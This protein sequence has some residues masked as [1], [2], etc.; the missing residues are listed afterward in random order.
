MGK[1]TRCNMNVT[2]DRHSAN[3]GQAANR[4]HGV[5]RGRAAN[6]VNPG[7]AGF[8]TAAV[9]VLLIVAVVAGAY[10]LKT[11]KQRAATAS[12]YFQARSATY[13]AQAG[14]DAALADLEAQPAQGTQTLNTFL[15]DTTK[16]WLFGGLSK[17]GSPNWTKLGEGG[18]TYATRLVAFDPATGLVKL[19]ARGRGPGGSESQVFGVYQLQG[20]KLVNDLLPRH[21]WYIAGD[22]RNIDETLDIDGNAYFGGNVHINGGADGTIFRGTVKVARG[23]GGVSS[24]DAGVTFAEHAYFQTPLTTQGAGLVFQ[25]GAGFEN[26]IASNTDMRMTGAGQTAYFNANISGGNAGINMLGNRVVHNGTLNMAR[27]KN[28][29]QVTQQ[30]GN[31]A[32]ANALGMT[33]TPDNEIS[34]DLSAIPLNKRFTL[35]SLGFASWGS[36]NGTD[37]SNA[38]A[39]AKATGRLY[40]DFLCINVNTGL[41]F[42]PAIPNTL[43]GKF[44]FIVTSSV[45]LNGNLPTSDP[46][47]VCLFYVGSGGSLQGFG[48]NGLFRGYVHVTGNGSIIY[49]WGNGAEFHGAIH[50]VSANSGFQMN[51]GLSPLKVVMDAGVFDDLASL[52]V[53]LPPG[54]VTPTPEPPEV[55][56]VDVRIRPKFLSRYF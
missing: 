5:N 8:A 52:Q 53:I 35:S 47:S 4:G 16:A 2:L 43:S 1:L 9:L 44:L 32:I 46:A 19:L 45:T 33:S 41:N 34:V 30:A 42:N 20:L 21:A 39:M 51:T 11:S 18:Q 14:L 40:Q 28:P 7:Q 24:F 23:S 17:A 54:V 25:K 6:P 56:L 3:A 48:G 22:A 27:V 15:A 29:G 13:A 12:N 36:T 26:S 31:V 10:M 49:Q 37:L 38:Y 55:Q 50:H